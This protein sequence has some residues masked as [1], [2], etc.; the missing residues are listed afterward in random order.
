MMCVQDPQLNTYSNS[1]NK[2]C[3]PAAPI[4]KS[5]VLPFMHPLAVS[6]PLQ[7]ANRHSNIAARRTVG[8]IRISH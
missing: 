4:N 2:P 3:T 7:H 8:A 1:P 5:G 6:R